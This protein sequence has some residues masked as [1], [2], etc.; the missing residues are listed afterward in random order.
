[1]TIRLRRLS[2]ST[3]IAAALLVAGPAAGQSAP[4]G[5]AAAADKPDG[6]KPAATPAPP[7]IRK[8]ADWQKGKDR[9]DGYFAFWRDPVNG[10]AFMEVMPDQIGPE[11][12]Y[13]TYTQDG[14]ALDGLRRLG[15][16]SDNY[17]LKLRRR[18]NRIDF[19]RQ[20]TL[21]SHDADSTLAGQQ[22]NIVN[23]LLASTTI[24]AADDA[25]GKIVIKVNDLFQGRDLIRIGEP[26]ALGRLLGV[27]AGTWSKE[28]SNIRSIRNYA[29]NSEIVA[30]YVFDYP[31]TASAT[32][33]VVAIQHNFVAMPAA[34]FTPR[35]EDPRVGF[36]TSRDTNLSSIDGTPWRDKIYR[37]RLE[38]KDPAAKLSEPVKPITYWID[39]ATPR[40]FRDTIRDAVLHWNS[41]FETMGFRN[42]VRVEI[43]PDDATWDAGDVGRNVIRWVASPV[44]Q[45]AGYG[46]TVVN[47]R[48]G[49]IIG[50]D[51]V[52]EH[53]T[54]QRW[55]RQDR[56]FPRTATSAAEA[57]DGEPHTAHDCSA[58]E[59]L[60]RSI[61]FAMASLN[62]QAG[63]TEGAREAARREIVRQGLYYL[64]LHE[65]GHTLGL[66]HNMM[67]SFYQPLSALNQPND[68]Y[69]SNLSNS[70]MDYPQVNIAPRGE[71]QGAYFPTRPGPYDYW[72]LA[73]AYDPALT[74]PAARTAH[75]AQSS[76]P[77]HAF[78][79]DG[80]SMAATG[81]GMD[82]R[83]IPY[84]L[85][86]EPVVFATRQM[87]MIRLAYG[88]LVDRTRREQGSW[89][90]M[91]RTYELLNG[92]YRQNVTAVSRYIGGVYVDR[93]AIGQET[94]A[95]A[96]FV[97]VARDT[98]KATMGLLGRYLFAPDAFNLPPDFGAYLQFQRRGFD[99]FGRPQDAPLHNDV[100]GLQSVAM[101]HLL[102]PATLQ[103]MADSS[104]YG[105]R[106]SANEMLGDL[107]GEIFD[108]DIRGS[109]NTF[110]QNLQATYVTRLIGAMGAAR[111]DAIA[112]SALFGE[113]KT[114]DARMKGAEGRGDE[115]T[116]AHRR[117]VRQLIFTALE[118]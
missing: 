52:L 2:F 111:M 110:R 59:G 41:V 112:R 64:A 72:A 8:M 77:E 38:K 85:S 102:A 92:M 46:P 100:L 105:N 70:I 86:S 10:D 116:K 51:I 39:K 62:L 19:I 75:L 115:R 31:K 76:R 88:E 66:S 21:Y 84:D 56:L 60:E 99:F 109:V 61:G 87:D 25:T 23:P 50:A 91:R 63:L 4:E 73:Y 45:Y 30:E 95:A 36:F 106:Y 33:G 53:A 97:P 82:P 69:G 26:S 104:L 40:E 90:E 47:P 35:P 42:A 5:D 96:P 6:E 65:V 37:W 101:S 54:V 22:D 58:S 15:S 83:V 12:I 14:T 44:P 67:G 7:R 78:G 24:V 55:I 117:Y 68:R 71:A 17:V 103:R 48:T 9:I 81:A 113:L 57:A 20:D 80:D 3:A 27:P 18:F 79:N 29:R 28:K 34:G 32:S 16:V 108:A 13:F 89:D 11:F 74:D 118:K 114:I 98:Q 1:M 93:S 107:S 49:E 94:R 43:Q